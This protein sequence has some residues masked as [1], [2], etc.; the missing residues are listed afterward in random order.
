LKR[1]HGG[2]V[3]F[4]IALGDHLMVIPQLRI[5]WIARE[6]DESAA[7]PRFLG[8]NPAQQETPVEIVCELM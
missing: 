2:G 1:C 3:D 5:H 6:D 8:L 7:S 4:P